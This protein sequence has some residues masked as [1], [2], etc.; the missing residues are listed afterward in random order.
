WHNPSWISMTHPSRMTPCTTPSDRARTGRRRTPS[1]TRTRSMQFCVIYLGTK[2][3][4][5]PGVPG[6]FTNRS[7]P[8]RWISQMCTIGYLRHAVG[9]PSSGGSTCGLY[10]GLRER[11]QP[12]G[13]SMT[14]TVPSDELCRL[15][16]EI[17]TLVGELGPSDER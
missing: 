5:P 15:F 1:R 3:A 12:K 14:T 4:R 6:R 16:Q 7:L 11:G 10:R 9:G 2:P 13:E 8:V 17:A